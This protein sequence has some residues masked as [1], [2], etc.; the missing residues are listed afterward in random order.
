MQIKQCKGM[1]HATPAT[2]IKCRSHLNKNSSENYFLRNKSQSWCLGAQVA[3][4]FYRKI[5]ALLNVYFSINRFT[6]LA[7]WFSGTDVGFYRNYLIDYYVFQSV[8]YLLQIDLNEMFKLNKYTDTQQYTTGIQNNF[9]LETDSEKHETLCDL[10]L[11]TNLLMVY[12]GMNP[13]WPMLSHRIVCGVQPVGT[14]QSSVFT[15]EL[16]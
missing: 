7:F 10:I 2:S 4:S 11:G 15:H 3:H 8:R 5:Q 14:K 13:T 1:C 9:P 12:T 6:S 16:H